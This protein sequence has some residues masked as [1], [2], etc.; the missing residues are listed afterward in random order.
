MGR[1]LTAAVMQTSLLMISVVLLVVSL[2]DAAGLKCEVGVNNETQILECE[3]SWEKVKMMMQEKMGSKW[4]MVQQN[5]TSGI[6][7]LIESMKGQ[8]VA[9]PLSMACGAL[10]GTGTVCVCNDQDVCNSAGPLRS[11]ALIVFLSICTITLSWV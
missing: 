7:N 10:P 9:E 11:L 3:G 6:T 1:Q 2:K 4:E 5:M 8:S